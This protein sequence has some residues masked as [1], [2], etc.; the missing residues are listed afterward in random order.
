[1]H[2]ADTRIRTAVVGYGLSG[3]VF[4]TPCIAANPRYSIEVIVTGDAQRAAAAAGRYPQA[5]V[6]ASVDDMLDLAPE[7]D[8]VVIG[9][10]PKT[11]FELAARAIRHGLHVVVDKPFVTTGEQGAALIERADKANVVLSVFQNRRWDADFLTLKRLAKEGALGRI[12]SFESRFERWSPR[13]RTAWKADTP[14]AEGGGILFDLGTHLIDQAIQL[15]GPVEKA[16]G[17]I[18]CRNADSSSG[19]DD[20]TFVSL[21][22]ASGTRSRLWMSR[23]AAQ[24]GPRF[25]VLGSSAAYT[26][27]GLDGQEASL[28][29]GQLPTDP[30][31]GVE[32]ESAWGML[33]HDGTLKAVRPERGSYP[34][35]YELLAA[36]VQDGG[37]V[38]VDPAESVE[39]L[40]I[41]E[42][43]HQL[44]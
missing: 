15:F 32:A 22:H 40:R 28:S 33:G 42:R 26:K 41:I 7:L 24:T 34:L 20:D 6:V 43:L 5:R 27:W 30:G 10:P 17:E 37:P 12:H 31:Y 14:A 44:G 36:A 19:A 13:S 21:L 11:H 1:M 9:T 35:F 23:L 4:H 18:D 8:L 16:Y 39:V 2:S 25:R 38:P 29:A 3:S